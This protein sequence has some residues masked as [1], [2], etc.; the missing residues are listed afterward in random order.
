MK[1]ALLVIDVQNGLC[2]GPWAMFDIDAVVDRINAV[3]AKARLAGVP[4]IFVQH[5][6]S[7]G[8]LQFGTNEWQIYERLA[9]RADEAHIRKTTPNSF[10]DTELQTLLQSQGIDRLIVCGLQSDF[11]VDATARGA[12]ALGYPVVLVSDAHTTMD[13]GELSAAQ[14]STNL[15]VALA[16][17]D[18]SAARVTVIAAADLQFER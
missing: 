5:E 16:N 14:I 18:G 1:S 7:E 8:P 2:T 10:H 9:T 11:C 17:L 13:N 15:N 4:V 12:V 3:A 6:E